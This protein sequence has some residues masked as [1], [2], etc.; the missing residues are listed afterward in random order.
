MEIGRDVRLIN[1]SFP[2]LN[3]VIDGHTSALQHGAT[4][5]YVGLHFNK[6]AS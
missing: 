6:R 4:T 5:L 3:D 1:T 2:I